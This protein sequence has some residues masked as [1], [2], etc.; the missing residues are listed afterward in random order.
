[1]GNFSERDHRVG[2]ERRQAFVELDALVAIAL[3]ISADE[4]CAIYRTQFP[5][6]VGYDR[7]S[8]VFD[9]NG[10]LVPTPVLAAWRQ[11]SEAVSP[12]D[13]TSTHPESG[14]SYEYELPFRALDR[15]QDLRHAYAR[16]AER[17]GI[18]RS[19]SS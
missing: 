7:S 14:V 17:S 4:L 18:R 13:R 16:L 1:M 12:T 8:S 3:N 19:N 10:R 9:K 5:V 15:A 2:A 11:K 6:L